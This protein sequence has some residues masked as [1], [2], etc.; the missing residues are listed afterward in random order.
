MCSDRAERCNIVVRHTVE[1]LT[2]DSAAQSKPPLC[3]KQADTQSTV[4][5]PCKF[6]ECVECPPAA[7][8]VTSTGAAR[9][10]SDAYLAASERCRY[11][12][13]LRMGWRSITNLTCYRYF[14]RAK[15]KTTQQG[16]VVITL[17]VGAVLGRVRIA[18]H[19]LTSFVCD[20]GQVQ[21]RF[22]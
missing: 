6:T 13:A 1:L 11:K 16:W 10:K 4:A 19:W 17:E 8:T 2:D 3:D 22:F 18:V 21:C 14:A 7:P 20:K 15:R 12:S 9:C 5:W